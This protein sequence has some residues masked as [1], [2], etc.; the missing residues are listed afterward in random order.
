M[1]SFF[2][3][4]SDPELVAERLSG[5]LGTK[6]ESVSAKPFAGGWEVVVA[7]RLFYTDATVSY[8]FNGDVFDLLSKENLSDG[9]RLE[10]TRD[11]V[12]ALP[13]DHAIKVVHG[14][15]KRR[16]VVFSDANCTYCKLLEQNMQ[17]LDNVTVLTFLIPALGESSAGRE[18]DIWCSK[19]RSQAWRDWMLVGRV[20]EQAP[21]LCESRVIEENAL[22]AHRLGVT[23][24]PTL[25]FA[26]GMKAPGSIPADQIEA[27]LQM[28]AAQEGGNRAEPGAAAP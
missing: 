9:R 3:P 2:V 18:R 1:L 25:F 27:M 4:I 12:A 26:N 15:G 7:D 6:K 11:R 13:E 28:A 24:T 21:A 20:P 5:L 10:I 8:L 23:G 22:I 14:K 16:L 19:D 17:S